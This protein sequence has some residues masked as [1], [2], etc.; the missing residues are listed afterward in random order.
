MEKKKTVT[1]KGS[2]GHGRFDGVDKG[3]E[4]KDLP[5]CRFSFPKFP[6]DKTTVVKVVNKDVDEN[7][8]KKRS[9]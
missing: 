1:I 6:L 8:L 9:Q 4:L 3:N 5:I 7:E 2:E